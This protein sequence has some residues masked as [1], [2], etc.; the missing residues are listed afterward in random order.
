MTKQTQVSDAELAGLIS[1]EMHCFEKVYEM[2]KDR[3]FYYALK[4]T[5]SEELAEEVVQD[6]FIKIWTNRKKIDPQYSFSSFVFRIAHNHAIN[7]L[8]RISY[9]KVAKERISK[10]ATVS[11]SDTEDYVIFKEYMGIVA[12]AIEQLPPK[13]K[14]IFNLSRT[15]GISHDD[16]ACE[17]GISKNTVKSQLVKATKSIKTYFTLHSGV[18]L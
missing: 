6:V 11:V 10:T 7:I 13:R 1:G 15:K 8:K 4:L 12:D 3:I 9:E 16:I 17:M 2:Y 18:A 5:K 14:S